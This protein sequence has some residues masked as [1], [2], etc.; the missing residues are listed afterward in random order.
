M[1][2][3]L[4]VLTVLFG[5]LGGNAIFLYSI[6]LTKILLLV[7]G[8]FYVMKPLGTH[9]LANLAVMASLSLGYGVLM[10]MIVLEFAARLYCP[11]DEVM[12]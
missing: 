2:F 4:P 8:L 6:L 3:F 7:A 9:R 11:L 12:E 5:G 1:G 10:F